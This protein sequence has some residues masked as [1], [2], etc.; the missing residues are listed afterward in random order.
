MLTIH[1][2][3]GAQRVLEKNDEKTKE[4]KMKYERQLTEL[5]T[6]LRSMKSARKEHAKAMKKNVCDMCLPLYL[7][8]SLFS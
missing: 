1:V 4:I 5:R 6:E 2:Y 7:R 8:H 3:V